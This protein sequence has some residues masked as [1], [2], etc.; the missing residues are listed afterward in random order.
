MIPAKKF[1]VF[2]YTEVLEPGQNPYKIVPTFWIKNEDSNNV[3]VPYPPEEELAQVFDRIF[4]CQLPLTGWEEKH[5]IIEREVDTY[6]A[7]MLY[8][9]RQNTVPLDEETLLVWKQIRLDCVEKIGTLQPIAV[10]RQLWTR[11]LNLVGI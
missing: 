6:Q 8:I 4:N 9:K 1:T 3:M 11:L 7:G 5:V 2:K 10:I